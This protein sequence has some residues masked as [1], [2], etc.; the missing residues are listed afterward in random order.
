MDNKTTNPKMYRG[1][2]YMHIDNVPKVVLGYCRMV[3]GINMK[4]NISYY[5]S[6]GYHFYEYV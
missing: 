3:E 4:K 2:I 6:G 1:R 5:Y